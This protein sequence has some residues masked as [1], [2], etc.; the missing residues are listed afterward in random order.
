MSTCESWTFP[1]SNH[2]LRL[3]IFGL[4]IAGPTRST[5]GL[6]PISDVYDIT[7]LAD[8]YDLLRATMRWARGMSGGHYFAPPP[9]P[10]DQD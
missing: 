3:K 6:A 10:P 7:V 8:R 2:S 4:A 5:S 1:S 9:P